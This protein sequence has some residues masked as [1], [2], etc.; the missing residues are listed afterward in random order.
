MQRTLQQRR[1]RGFSLIELMVALVIGMVLTLA[2]FALLAA[3]EGRK[4][5]TTGL[6]DR[7][8]RRQQHLRL[9]AARDRCRRPDAAESRGAPGAICVGQSGWRRQLPAAAGDDPARRDGTR[10]KR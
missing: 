10:R 5:I 6:N 7:C 4:R 2:V 3:W 1:Q 8:S 9:P